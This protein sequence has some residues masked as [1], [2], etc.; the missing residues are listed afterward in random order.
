MLASVQ[1][2]LNETDIADQHLQSPQDSKFEPI[3]KWMFLREES[4]LPRRYLSKCLGPEMLTAQQ[5]IDAEH[6][7]E[8]D[9][10]GE[11]DSDIVILLAT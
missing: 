1:P 2:V 7:Y 10:V 5:V 8:N 6:D 9:G 11:G 4:F 3:R